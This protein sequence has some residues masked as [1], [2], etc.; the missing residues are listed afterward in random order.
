MDDRTGWT[1]CTPENECSDPGARECRCRRMQ[2][3]TREQRLEAAVNEAWRLL[4]IARSGCDRTVRD[5]GSDVRLPHEARMF[6]LAFS[7]EGRDGP[8]PLQARGNGDVY[9]WFKQARE[10]LTNG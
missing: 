1:P 6:A 4:V 9:R 5:L 7:P 8:A 10:A 2:E 3:A